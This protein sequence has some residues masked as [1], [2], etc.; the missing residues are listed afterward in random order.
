MSYS[1]LACVILERVV[2]GVQ[3]DDP[4]DLCHLKE[5]QAWMKSDGYIIW[6]ELGYVTKREEWDQWVDHRCPNEG[7][8]SLKKS[9]KN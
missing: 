7:L 9:N 1:D 6:T 5:S 2:N 3:S 8:Y 4:K